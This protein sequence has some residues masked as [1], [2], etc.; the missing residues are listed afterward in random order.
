MSNQVN[1]AN[2]KSTGPGMKCVLTVIIIAEL[3]AVAAITTAT[4]FPAPPIE[5]LTLSD[6]IP[7]IPEPN[8]ADPVNYVEWINETF[9]K[10]IPNDVNKLYL[11]AA[12][13]LIEFDHQSEKA[14]S[15]LLSQLLKQ[16]PRFD[17]EQFQKIEMWLTANQRAIALYRKAAA[18]NHAFLPILPPGQNCRT[19]RAAECAV[20][21]RLPPYSSFRTL[22]KALILQGYLDLQQGNPSTLI[23]NV[24]ANLNAARHI[25]STPTIITGLVSNSIRH[26]GYTAI[27]R[28]LQISDSP[29]SLANEISN[30][31]LD[32]DQ[33]PRPFEFFTI[34]N[35]IETID[36][37]QRAYGPERLD[38]KWYPNDEFINQ[39]S[40][41]QWSLRVYQLSLVSHTYEE[42]IDVLNEIGD[43]QVKLANAPAAEVSGIEDQITA[44][45][46]AKTRSLKTLFQEMPKHSMILTHI[47]SLSRARLSHDKT[48]ATRSALHLT[49][50]IFNY[51][52]AA[53]RFP[54]TLNDLPQTDIESIRNDPFTGR[55]LIYRKIPEGF[56]LYS[57]ADNMKDDNAQ[58]DKTWENNDYVFWPVPKDQG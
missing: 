26:A 3:L 24:A 43:L 41:F 13:K 39:C 14:G 5:P 45:K 8:P 16:A 33:P 49:L 51:K 57:A 48:I 21:Y 9:G 4:F 29:E 23:E 17:S 18:S 12:D 15:K 28:A 30:Q 53:G 22:S 56:T 32:A 2:A 44:I 52:K 7:A 40:A 27:F 6:E 50:Q 19:G 36:L 35:R 37:A 55:D 20:D 47:P 58:H 54:D 46:S 11:H 34:G 25:G 38:G 1:S 42:T 10:Y 31:V